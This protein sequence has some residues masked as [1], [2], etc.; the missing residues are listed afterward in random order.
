MELNPQPT[1]LHCGAVLPS[2]RRSYCSDAHKLR[3][4]RRRRAGVEQDAFPGG[5]RKSRLKWRGQQR[6]RELAVMLSSRPSL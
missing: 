2:A 4:F 6:H 1:C 3:A 5:A